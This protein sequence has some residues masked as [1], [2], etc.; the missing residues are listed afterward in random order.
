[1][2]VLVVGPGNGL[3]RPPVPPAAVGQSFVQANPT[4]SARAKSLANSLLAPF[5]IALDPRIYRA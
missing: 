3:A 1:M 4:R 2:I 5:G